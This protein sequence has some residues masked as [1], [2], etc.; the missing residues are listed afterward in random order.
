MEIQRAV[1][2]VKDWL[3]RFPIPEG[4]DFSEPGLVRAFHH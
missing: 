2:L 1:A 4:W 3:M